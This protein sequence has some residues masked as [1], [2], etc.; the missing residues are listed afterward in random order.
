MVIDS[1]A[2]VKIPTKNNLWEYGKQSHYTVFHI[3]TDFAEAFILPTGK[4]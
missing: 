4:S 1:W 2:T 3:P